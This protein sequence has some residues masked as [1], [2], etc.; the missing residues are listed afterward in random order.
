MGGYVA[1]ER[2][3]GLP[4]SMQCNLMPQKSRKLVVREACVGENIE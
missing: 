4:R 1:L 3:E 2:K